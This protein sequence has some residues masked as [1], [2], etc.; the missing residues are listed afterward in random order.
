MEEFQQDIYKLV[1]ILLEIICLN[2]ELEKS[3]IKE[4]FTKGEK[5]FF[6]TKVSYYLACSRPNMID[7]LRAQLDASGLSLLFQDNEVPGLQ[8]VNILS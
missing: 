5:F 8:K 6:G 3:Y 1:E 2:L 4:V 7:D